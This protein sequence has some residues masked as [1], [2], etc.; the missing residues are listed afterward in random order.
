VNEDGTMCADVP[1]QLLSELKRA[2]EE[3]EEFLP[4]CGGMLAAKIASLLNAAL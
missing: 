3:E 4:S 2:V 1:H